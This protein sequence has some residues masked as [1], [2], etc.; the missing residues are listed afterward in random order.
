VDGTRSSPALTPA[1]ASV[2][3]R[4][5]TA[6][7][8]LGVRVSFGQGRRTTD[9]A[10]VVVKGPRADVLRA[11]PALAEGLDLDVEVVRSAHTADGFEMVLALMLPKSQRPRHPRERRASEL[12]GG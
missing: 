12:G 8:R 10:L 5:R 3:R 7:V 9:V 6:A 4:V 2:R 11:S 1:Q